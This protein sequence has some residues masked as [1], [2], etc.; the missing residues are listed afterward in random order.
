MRRQGKGTLGRRRKRQ[1]K[2]ERER[3][4][5]ENTRAEKTK[6]TELSSP[7]KIPHLVSKC[8]KVRAPITSVNSAKPSHLPDSSP[9]PLHKQAENDFNI[10]E[11]SR[12]N[13][14]LRGKNVCGGAGGEWGVGGQR[15][16]FDAQ[17]RHITR[18]DINTL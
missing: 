5:G 8:C 14:G 13:V 10:Q 16:D 12:A 1:R 11:S 7:A 15:S 4:E 2:R 17:L 9:P 6:T 18:M 3:G